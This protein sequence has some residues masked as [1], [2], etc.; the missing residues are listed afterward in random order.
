MRWVKRLAREIAMKKFLFLSVLSM[1][2]IGCEIE[3]KGP[4]Q[5]KETFKVNVEWKKGRKEYKGILNLAAGKNYPSE[6]KFNSK[7][8]VNLEI[9]DIKF[10]GKEIDM[11][12]EF[13][14]PKGTELPERNGSFFIAASDS[15]QHVDVQGSVATQFSSSDTQ[16]DRES[17]TYTD[18]ERK[19]EKQCRQV[20]P[21]GNDR[22][23]DRDRG[24][25]RHRNRGG[26]DFSIGEVDENGCY[27]K[28]E[29]VFKVVEVT[30]WGHQDVEF[31][32]EYEDRDYEIQF[33]EA[34]GQAIQGVF[35]GRWH[36]SDKLYDYK[37][38]C[39]GP[40]SRIWHRRH[41]HGHHRN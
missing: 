7:K 3:V 4:I 14:I 30:K 11:K 29:T 27:Q 16:F 26:N 19:R 36:D 35:I 34:N 39:E 37:G 8:K 5:V 32:F 18:Y 9:K 20:C 24:R 25:G 33:V 22:G 38:F 28:C 13:K 17:C 12:A 40:R 1:T 31:H 10:E 6:I 2:M 23:R 21:Q 41:G 15:G